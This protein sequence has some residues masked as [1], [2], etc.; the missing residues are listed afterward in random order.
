[1]KMR[2]LSTLAVSV[3]GSML[4]R[5]LVVPALVTG[6]TNAASL[7]PSETRQQWEDLQVITLDSQGYRAK[8]VY[9]SYDQ[10]LTL[11][12]VTVKTDAIPTPTHRQPTPGSISAIY[13]R[14]SAL[15]LPLM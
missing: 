8:T 3:I 10:L 1:M 15:T 5:V 11:P 13:S 14:R 2:L 7:Q 12:T 9:Y 6:N 4:P